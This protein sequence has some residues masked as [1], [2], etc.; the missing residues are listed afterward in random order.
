MISKLKQIYRIIFPIKVKTQ[1]YFEKQIAWLPDYQY[2]SKDALFYTITFRSFSIAMR[3]FGQSDMLVY[4]QIFINE[5]YKIVKEILCNFKR[6]KFYIIDAGANVGYTSL[7]FALGTNSQIIAVEPSSSNIEILNKNIEL[8][9]LGNRIEVKNC[10]LSNNS[11]NKYKIENKFRDGLD[12][13]TTTI[14]DPNG[15]VNSITIEE[16]FI[17]KKWDFID[18]LKIDIEGAEAEIFKSEVNFLSK[19]RVIAVEVHDEFISRIEIEL[20]LKNYGFI[21]F[22]FSELT[23]G[24]NISLI[25]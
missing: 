23:I 21:V 12:W 13:S 6:V 5:E 2:Y 24:V 10:A 22:N 17:E 4:N 20:I 8:N 25:S 7:Y 15:K 14:L 1:E 19:T 16:I 11:N 3:G 9:N 18:L